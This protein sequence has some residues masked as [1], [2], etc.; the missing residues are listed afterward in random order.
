MQT[1]ITYP[2]SFLNQNSYVINVFSITE[3]SRSTW[4]SIA[5]NKKTS[6]IDVYLGQYNYEGAPMSGFIHNWIAIGL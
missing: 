2:I 5:T 4:H 1:K 3:D 6:S